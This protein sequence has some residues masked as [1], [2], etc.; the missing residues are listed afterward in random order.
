MW[1]QFCT[2][3][4]LPLWNWFKVTGSFVRKIKEKNTSAELSGC[5]TVVVPKCFTQVPKCLAFTPPPPPPNFNDNVA[6]FDML[7]VT[8]RWATIAILSVSVE[9][10]LKSSSSSSS[11]KVHPSVVLS[12]IELTWLQVKR[13]VPPFCGALSIKISI[14]PI[15]LPWR[16]RAM[17]W[18]LWCVACNVLLYIVYCHGHPTLKL[19]ATFKDK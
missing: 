5:R 18:V 16:V 17:Q 4:P 19:N 2:L 3:T 8:R 7:L 6:V 13:Y 14:A 15:Y 12:I 9:C 10:S 11:N 1:G